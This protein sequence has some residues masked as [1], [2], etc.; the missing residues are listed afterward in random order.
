[1]EE[2]FYLAWPILVVGL[3]LLG[4]G[5]HRV[6][7]A[8]SVVAATA[9]AV[10][11]AAIYDPSNP[12]RAYYG[13]DTRTSQILIGA[14]L[15]MAVAKGRKPRSRALVESV[16]GVSLALVVVALLTVKE[17]HAYLFRGGY[18]AFSF[19]MAFLIWAVSAPTPTVASRLL[20]WRP[21]TAIGEISYGL[22]LWHWPVQVA[23][24]ESRTPLAGWG[25]LAVRVA[26]TFVLAVL[27]SVLI[28]TP[29]RRRRGWGVL[30][31]WKSPAAIAA[32]A[33][34]AVG[35]TV[36]ATA[37]ATP[38]P[39]Y[40]DGD[41]GEVA[42]DGVAP[43]G[44]GSG[45]N[46]LVMVG[47]SLVLSLSEGMAQVSQERN[48]GFSMVARWGCGVLDLAPS[49]HICHAEHGEYVDR[50]L[51]AESPVI[52]WMSNLD[53]VANFY[54]EPPEEMGEWSEDFFLLR[55]IDEVAG[56]FIEAGSRV[57]FV[58]APP[59]SPPNDEGPMT[60]ALRR[61]HR[62]FRMYHVL[63]PQNTL[64][65]DLSS[66]ICGD[67]PRCPATT[68]GIVLRPTDG[69]HYES[70]GSYWVANWMF[71]QLISSASTDTNQSSNQPK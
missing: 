32:A 1:V 39:R 60:D 9:S 50:I 6:L 38:P 8:F 52:V 62:V 27:S 16:G 3:L 56:R 13:T 14:L 46:R 28:E 31:G 48:W 71:D 17:S 7:V 66:A 36:V 63:R 55:K 42:E 15:A 64:L 18:V 67:A 61:T 47:D 59:P 49:D 43:G 25:L 68:D 54:V 22:Y 2:Q 26:V 37:G 19:A 20:S 12:S 4:R 35:S 58:L 57:A 23:I 11:M 70:E 53:N 40:L 69:V 45:S 24:S 5:R 34:I 65:L 10:W 41:V 44:Q 30:G 29:V 21:L 33:A 51:R